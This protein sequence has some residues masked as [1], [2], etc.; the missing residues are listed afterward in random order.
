MG[1]FYLVG[2]MHGH[3][4]IPPETKNDAILMDEESPGKVN[5]SIAITV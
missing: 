5:I 3:W 1:Q 4:D 2:L